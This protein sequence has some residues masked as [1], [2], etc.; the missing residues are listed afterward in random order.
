MR[1]QL[2]YRILIL[3]LALAQWPAKSLASTLTEHRPNDTKSQ[4]ERNIQQT[5][6]PVLHKYCA[7]DCKVLS[8]KASLTAGGAGDLFTPGF[9]EAPSEDEI[10]VERAEVK[11]LI[12]DRLGKTRRTRINDLLNQLFE[13]SD[14][15]VNIQLKATK[16]PAEADSSQ[17]VSEIREKI[18]KNFEGLTQ[19][20]FQKFCPRN[21]LFSQFELETEVVSLEEAQTGN[22]SDYFEYQGT[23]VR[24][25][26]IGGTLVFDR[27][28]PE[29]DQK[30]LFDLV[31]LR[32]HPY[33]NL[34]L[35]TKVIDFPKIK[36]EESE[37]WSSPFATGYGNGNTSERNLNRDTKNTAESKS[38]SDSEEKNTSLRNDSRTEQNRT[39]SLTK[40]SENKEEKFS[41]YEKIERVESGDALHAEFQQIKLFGAVISAM[42]LL[43]LGWI[44]FKNAS[45]KSQ[46]ENEITIQSMA[47][48]APSTLSTTPPEEPSRL[49]RATKV[50][51][52][53]RFQIQ[54]LKDSLIT[55]F[56][57]NPR[58]TKHVFTKI[59]TEEGI[60]TTAAYISIFGETVVMEILRDPSLQSDINHLIEFYAT[61]PIELSDED[62]IELLKKLQARSI[63]GKLTILSQNNKSFF[64]FMS[65]LDPEQIYALI[66]EESLPVKGLVVTQTDHQKRSELLGR[67]D[68]DSR[69]K[70]MSELSRMEYLPKE[71][72]RNVAS[73]LRRKLKENPQL[74]TEPL[75]SQEVLMSLLEEGT[76]EAQSE[77]IRSLEETHPKNA[78]KIKSQFVTLETLQYLPAGKL[79]EVLLALK[80]DELLVLFKGMESSLMNNVIQ[81][82]P[83]DLSGDLQEELQSTPVPGREQLNAIERKVIHRLKALASDKVID[84]YEVNEKLFNVVPFRKVG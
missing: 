44:L 14:F 79:V 27:I 7:D 67:F 19:D 16:F 12:D 32:A 45:K 53:L 42:I 47:P 39:D 52:T 50:E 81:M 11:I 82:L 73:A 8:I 2:P 41:R 13:N 65:D 30:N 57:E 38:R 71:Y 84:L 77:F 24:I 70:L 25:D 64:D 46:S 68:A 21:C 62:Q 15:P 28:I 55:L 40:N 29:A 43:L 58:V 4:S 5:I 36:G 9:E 31:Q 56:V 51:P 74:N 83:A 34:E 61:T 3:L 35:K 69:S 54:N 23:A 22:P 1:N 63:S 49:V 20:V 18:R 75:A 10:S 80:H 59:L 60:E 37:S 76:I 26:Q 78:K 33:S 72:I 17:K 66:R 6:E 48:P